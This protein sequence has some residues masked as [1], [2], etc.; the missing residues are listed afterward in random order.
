MRIPV[1]PSDRRQEAESFCMV[2]QSRGECYCTLSAG[3]TWKL[4]AHAKAEIIGESVIFRGEEK[5]EA[6]V[7]IQELDRSCKEEK[8]RKKEEREREEKMKIMREG[9]EDRS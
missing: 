6:L 2:T 5:A 1:T 8:G 4:I 7:A 9:R 3:S